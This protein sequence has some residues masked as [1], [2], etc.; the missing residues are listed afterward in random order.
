MHTYEPP[1]NSATIDICEAWAVLQ[2]AKDRLKTPETMAAWT[3]LETALSEVARKYYYAK[4][5]GKEAQA[6]RN[7]DRTE[8]DKAGIPVGPAHGFYPTY[9]Q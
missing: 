8:I 2:E 9:V 5:S 7:S 1:P 4:P 3:T 6:V